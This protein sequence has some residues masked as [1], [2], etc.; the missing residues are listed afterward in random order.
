M[1]VGRHAIEELLFLIEVL[2]VV[3]LGTHNNTT[4]SNT[5]THPSTSATQK[6][7]LGYRGSGTRDLSS[8]VTYSPPP[9]HYEH[10]VYD[11]ITTD[12]MA[13]MGTV[14][15]SYVLA[16]LVSSIKASTTL[17]GLRNVD[18]GLTLTSGILPL[19]LFA[20]LTSLCPPQHT[21]GTSSVLADSLRV[22]LWLCMGFG[23][24]AILSILFPLLL[25]SDN[26]HV[27]GHK[28][29]KG[30]VQLHWVMSFLLSVVSSAASAAFGTYFVCVYCPA[31]TVSTHFIISVLF[32]HTVFISI[33]HCLRWWLPRT[34]SF[35]EMVIV[36]QCMSLTLWDFIAA[37]IFHFGGVVLVG[38]RA[39]VSIID[40]DVSATLIATSVFGSATLLL[41]APLAH[42]LRCTPVHL[43]ATWRFWLYASLIGMIVCCCTGCGLLWVN[44]VRSVRVLPWLLAFMFSK[45]SRWLMCIYWLAAVIGTVLVVMFMMDAV[46]PPTSH[47]TK[48][49]FHHIAKTEGQ[50]HQLPTS[51]E[52]DENDTLRKVFHL[53]AVLMF[54]PAIYMDTNLLRLCAGAALF[55][56]L[57]VE[58]MRYAAVSPLAQACTAFMSSLASERH[59]SGVAVLTHVYLL[60]GLVTPVWLASLTPAK[61]PHFL[62]QYSGILTI[63]VGDAT[64]SVI[65]RRFGQH[66]WPGTVKT[67]EGTLAA[68]FAVLVA[69]CGVVFMFWC[70]GGGGSTSWEEEGGLADSFVVGGRWLWALAVVAATFL[71]ML[72]EALT[73][74]IDNLV[75]P[76]RLFS[77]LAVLPRGVRS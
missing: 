13:L 25:G 47:T 6:T 63:G 17:R 11:P 54:V 60:A 59:D 35:T 76:I 45:T 36:V 48:I 18:L 67:V 5:N 9:H 53:A 62:A 16:R 49:N 7:T 70:G 31:P 71:S 28:D 69:C 50:S 46:P 51:S 29:S 61:P 57:L 66:R 56:M 42:K 75:L 74:Q 65:G 41:C 39:A 15:A 38:S 32:C 34:F 72:A 77:L 19:S 40:S 37:T 12:A 14:V 33:C 44:S 52:A 2:W 20:Q 22:H 24:T 23:I 27:G 30:G 8:P 21:Y 64:A 26:C 43:R 55:L 73:T 3:L 10:Y 1:H 68:C 58:L 4:T